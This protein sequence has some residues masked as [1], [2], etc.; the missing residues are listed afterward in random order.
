MQPTGL[1]LSIEGFSRHFI[2]FD[3]CLGGAHKDEFIDAT[4]DQC[5]AGL[6]IPSHDL[7]QI[8]WGPCASPCPACSLFIPPKTT[9][10]ERHM[11]PRAGVGVLKCTPANIS[12]KA[13]MKVSYVQIFQQFIKIGTRKHNLHDRVVNKAT[14]GAS[15]PVAA[16]AAAMIRP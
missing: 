15:L 16:R 14:R 12:L 9:L 4:G 2:G 7:H 6:A 10:H 13:L 3:T 11:L 1:D 8:R 5:I